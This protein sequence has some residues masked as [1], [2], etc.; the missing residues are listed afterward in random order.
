MLAIFADNTTFFSC[1]LN[2]KIV[3]ERLK[4]DIELYM[5]WFENNYMKLNEDTFHLLVAGYRHET[6]STQIGETRILESTNEKLL[7]LIIDRNLNFDVY[8]FTLCKKAGRK[9][10]A[11][12]WISNYMSFE[13]KRIFLK[14]FVESQFEY[15]PLIWI[16]H[17]RKA[18]SKINHIHE[19]ALR[20]VYND[21]IS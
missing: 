6:T 4:H 16:F 3:M 2:L 5:E 12:A 1:D 14:A 9:L 15:C 8:A 13:K 17:S 11:L 21:N 19:R 7:G 18:N 20:I 10:S